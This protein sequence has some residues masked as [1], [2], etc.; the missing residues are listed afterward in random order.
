LNKGKGVK[1]GL[2]CFSILFC[3]WLFLTFIILTTAPENFP[4]GTGLIELAVFTFISICV[5]L[6]VAAKSEKNK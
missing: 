1:A 4:L 6:F 2:I 3:I 5:G